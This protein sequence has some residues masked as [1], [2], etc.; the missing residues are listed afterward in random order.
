MQGLTGEPFFSLEIAVFRLIHSNLHV[1]LQPAS[2]TQTTGLTLINGAVDLLRDKNIDNSV[3]RLIDDKLSVDVPYIEQVKTIGNAT[4]HPRGWMVA[5]VY[6]ALLPEFNSLE[7]SG[8][9]PVSRLTGMN[10][11]FDHLALIHSCVKRMR[12]KTQYT[13]VPLHMMPEEFTL[14]DL[15]RC[16]EG[17]LSTSLEKKSFRRRLLDANVLVALGKERRGYARPAQL[18]RMKRGH[19]VHHFSRKM[20]GT[21]K[22]FA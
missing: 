9:F 13:T 7:E 6:Y 18:Y 10:L 19:I 12:D 14:T 15:Q 17:L 20:R 8:W 4:R 16:Y 21:A 3:K 11:A 5:A 22:E 1:Y 2:G